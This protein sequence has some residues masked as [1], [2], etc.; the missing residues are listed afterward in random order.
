M[1]LTVEQLLQRKQESLSL[2]VLAGE[3]GLGREIRAPEAVHPVSFA[4]QDPSLL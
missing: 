2:K 1:T 3:S 4:R